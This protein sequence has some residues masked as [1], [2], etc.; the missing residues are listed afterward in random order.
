MNGRGAAL[1]Q[2]GTAPSAPSGVGAQFSNLFKKR[3]YSIGVLLFIPNHI[4]CDLRK[5]CIGGHISSG[6]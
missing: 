1:T 2:K 5:S 6:G 4:D 3:N